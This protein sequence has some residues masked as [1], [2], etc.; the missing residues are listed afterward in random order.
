[1]KGLTINEIKIGDVS[2]LL[3]QLEMLILHYL[4]VTAETSILHISM[5]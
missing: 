5:L 2:T 4:P 3:K 1:M